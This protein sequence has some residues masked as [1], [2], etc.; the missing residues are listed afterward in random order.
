MLEQQS[1]VPNFGNITLLAS[2]NCNGEQ[3]GNSCYIVPAAGVLQSWT[4]NPPLCIEEMIKQVS[5]I[6]NSSGFNNNSMYCSY[7]ETNVFA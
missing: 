4:E 6:A 1:T 2:F 5:V 3:V 7:L